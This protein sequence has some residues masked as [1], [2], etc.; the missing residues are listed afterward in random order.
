M[1]SRHVSHKPTM[2]PTVEYSAS[3][4]STDSQH[5]HTPEPHPNQQ[6]IT[7]TQLTILI[8]KFCNY[9]TEV[10]LRIRKAAREGHVVPVELSNIPEATAKLVGFLRGLKPAAGYFKPD[11]TEALYLR[12][13]GMQRDYQGLS[14][15]VDLWI[16]GQRAKKIVRFKPVDPSK[17]YSNREGREHPYLFSMVG[18]R[19]VL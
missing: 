14:H 11:F 4:R 2:A 10:A 16:S 18:A 1:A 5:S 8:D 9:A 3:E 7:P 17:L 13:L 15:N 6:Q 12:V 19:S